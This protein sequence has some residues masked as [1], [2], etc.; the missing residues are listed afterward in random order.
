MKQIAGLSPVLFHL[1]GIDDAANIL[2]SKRFELKPSDGTQAEEEIR[3][4]YY[5]STARSP[6]SAY[7]AK[8]LW[9]FSVV[10]ELDG[11]KLA[12]KYKGSAIDYWGP[13]YYKD[14]NGVP[15]RKRHDR[16]EAEDR[17]FAPTPF[18]PS[19]PYIRA[20][21]G[22]IGKHPSTKIQQEQY[23]LRKLCL[24][25]KIP[26]YF[27][28]ET[29]DLLQR[30]KAKAV[31]F[32][33][34][35]PGPDP[36]AYVYPREALEQQAL[37]PRRATEDL[38]CWYALWMIPKKSGV[39]SYKQLDALGNKRIVKLYER[40]R[41]SDAISGLMADMHNAKSVAYDRPD[42]AREHLDQLVRMLRTELMTPK[43]FIRRLQD[44]WY[45]QAD[46]HKNYA[47]LSGDTGVYVSVALTKVSE[48]VLKDWL[49]EH[50]LNDWS[51]T[52]EGDLHCTVMYSKT[53]ASNWVQQTRV[54]R[55]RA[56]GFDLFGPDNNTLVVRLWSPELAE[57]NAAWRSYGCVPTYPDYKPHITVSFKTEVPENAS[58]LIEAYNAK[59]R[60]KPLYLEFDPEVAEDLK[61]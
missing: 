41:Y 36:D 3:Q 20:I 15:E 16:F 49:K 31:A 35:K 1:T 17:V 23:D 34:A 39:E 45:P 2:R 37:D 10:L 30:N 29:K 24:L 12:Q 22:M 60:I 25:N 21:Y 6:N 4:S 52:N 19:I 11:A 40:L 9:S 54:T 18:I 56:L 50:V 44:K 59:L 28:N 32:K 46:S 48:Q 38:A 47:S 27:F 43:E 57:R 14:D 13:K 53:P 26:L 58:A 42:K 51:F 61:D 33:P 55:A 5:L 8:G 7:I